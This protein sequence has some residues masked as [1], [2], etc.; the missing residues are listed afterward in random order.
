MTFQNV[1]GGFYW[2]SRD[3][4]GAFQEHSRSILWAFQWHSKD[5]PWAF[6]SHSIGIPKTFFKAFQL[7]L[8]KQLIFN[9]SLL[10]LEL[11]NDLK[12]PLSGL[13]IKNMMAKL[14]EIMDSFVEKRITG[15]RK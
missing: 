13:F 4:P 14:L 7:Q 2:H 15:P 5:I 12:F 8:K 11:L 6:H 3:V 9:V 1:P 10:F